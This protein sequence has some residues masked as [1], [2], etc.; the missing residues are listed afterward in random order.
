MNRPL[1]DGFRSFGLGQPMGALGR[2]PSFDPA[3]RLE[4][5]ATGGDR[6][7]AVSGSWLGNVRRQQHCCRSSSQGLCLLWVVVQL[8]HRAGLQHGVAE[9]L[10]QPAA[11]FAFLLVESHRLDIFIKPERRRTSVHQ[12]SSVLQLVD[13]IA[14]LVLL[15]FAHRFYSVFR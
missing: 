8:Q 2:W 14:I 13:Y 6:P 12:C 9:G 11:H 15:A 1:C 3:G 7:G 5:M 4:R 10:V